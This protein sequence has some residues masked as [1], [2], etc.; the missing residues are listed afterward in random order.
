M[1]VKDYE[2][3]LENLDNY[4]III[5]QLGNTEPISISNFISA[6]DILFAIKDNLFQMEAYTRLNYKILNSKSNSIIFNKVNNVINRYN[7]VLDHTNHLLTKKYKLKDVLSETDNKDIVN[8]IKSIY[9]IKKVVHEDM[10]EIIKYNDKIK[11]K[12]LGHKYNENE[13]INT[14]IEYVKNEEFYAHECNYKRYK[15]LILYNDNVSYNTIDILTNT[16]S[17]NK[18]VFNKI[19]NIL[20]KDYKKVV[21]DKQFSKYNIIT[22]CEN[23]YNSNLLNKLLY[24]F[25]NC[26]QYNKDDEIIIA[27][28][29]MPKIFVNYNNDIDSL[30]RLTDYISKGL[31]KYSYDINNNDCII[32]Y[33][34]QFIIL[35]SLL[36]NDNQDIHYNAY[37]GLLSIFYK[38][39]NDI[40]ILDYVD[41]IHNN[42]NNINLNYIKKNKN[43]SNDLLMIFNNYSEY[44]DAINICIAYKLYRDNIRGNDL[45]KLC[46]KDYFGYDLNNDNVINYIVNNVIDSIYNV[47]KK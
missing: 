15:D 36:D 22:S 25:D 42:I 14:I 33:L 30:L 35:D 17:N 46:K 40:S 41:G 4:N 6:Y 18:N 23:N 10:T 13:L 19:N 7:N 9:R 28:N 43:Y 32:G 47:I 38:F 11:N 20:S 37:I 24:V 5:D 3:S 45:I 44:N 21:M 34:N 16:W 2:I 12:L 39:I 29:L 1:E 26:I 27:R 31:Y 8:Y